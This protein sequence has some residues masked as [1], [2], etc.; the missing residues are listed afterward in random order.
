MITRKAKEKDVTE[1]LRITQLEILQEDRSRQELKRGTT[2]G[3]I[4]IL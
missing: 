4:V 2:S 1:A 3:T